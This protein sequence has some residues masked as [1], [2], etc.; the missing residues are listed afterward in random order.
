MF[1]GHYAVAFALK[2]IAP[3]LSLG[4]LFVAVQLTDL[5]FPICLLL[6]IEELRIVPGITAVSP[7]EFVHYP[8]THSLLSTVMWAIGLAM[9]YFVVR[10][11]GRCAWVI[12]LAVL[13]H[14]I[15]DAVAHR[16]DL[17]LLP[18]GDLYVLSLIHI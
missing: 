10:R 14:W 11:S 6:G 1:V 15:L 5:I 17:P 13:S 2:P 4:M 16:P 3:K 7:F 8:I 18:G 9:G 12:G